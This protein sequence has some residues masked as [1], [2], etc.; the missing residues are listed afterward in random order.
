MRDARAHVRFAFFR[1]GKLTSLPRLR[2]YLLAAC[3]L[4]ERF[5]PGR[6]YG[7][8]EMNA[9]LVDDAPDPATLRRLLVDER[10]LDR[11]PDAYWRRRA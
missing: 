8:S 10:S 11:E 9:I 2:A 6:R 1:D 5:E 4:A 3:E 7:E